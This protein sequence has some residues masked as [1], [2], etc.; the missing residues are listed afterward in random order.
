MSQ[1]QPSWRHILY[2]AFL[3]RADYKGSVYPIQSENDKESELSI[4]RVA[5]WSMFGL[6]VLWLLGITLFLAGS[7][8]VAVVPVSVI[9]D[10]DLKA[11]MGDRSA[12]VSAVANIVFVFQILPQREQQKSVESSINQEKNKSITS[13]VRA[14]VNRRAHAIRALAFLVAAGDTRQ[15]GF[16]R[17]GS[18]RSLGDE[19]G[20]RF[21]A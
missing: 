9:R 19:R 2:R 8:A 4:R 12:K 7:G 11:W 18:V 10:L 6:G 3:T 1:E 5:A 21:G 13:G 15:S 16:A 17:P 20:D 14:L